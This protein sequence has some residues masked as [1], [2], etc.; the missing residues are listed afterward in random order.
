FDVLVG[1]N[2][3]RE[4][5][6]LPEVSLVAI[7]DADKEGF[8]RSETSLIQTIGRAARNAEGKVI[9]YADEI[10]GSMRR[11]IEETYRRRRIQEEFNRRHGITPQTVRKAVRDV[12]EATR[13]AEKAPEYLAGKSLK[14]IPRRQIPQVIEKLRKEMQQAARDLEFER[15]AILRDMIFEL[16]ELQRGGARRQMGSGR[17]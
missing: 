14:E 5:L 16:E 4:G 10:T 9:M 13:V 6:D 2:L 1:I 7:L 12:I 11:A 17:R 8:L 15:A 3:L